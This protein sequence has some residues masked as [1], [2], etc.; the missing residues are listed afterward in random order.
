MNSELLE[1]TRH[2]AEI[3]YEK[4]KNNISMKNFI[5]TLQTAR[6][7][8]DLCMKYYESI[9]ANQQKC[10]QNANSESNQE[11]LLMLKSEKFLNIDKISKNNLDYIFLNSIFHALNIERNIFNLFQNKLNNS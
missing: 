6:K 1:I 4:F 5:N 10:V 8:T 3:S 2:D 11:I 7:Y 9:N